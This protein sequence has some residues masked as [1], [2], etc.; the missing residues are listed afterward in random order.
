L[1]SVITAISILDSIELI[2][3]LTSYPLLHERFKA[4]LAKIPEQIKINSHETEVRDINNFG[5]IYTLLKAIFPGTRIYVNN[6]EFNYVW[7]CLGCDIFVVTSKEFRLFFL[8]ENLV[9]KKRGRTILNEYK[10]KIHKEL[11][12]LVIK[13][14]GSYYNDS[15]FNYEEGHFWVEEKAYRYYPVVRHLTITWGGCRQYIFSILMHFV[16][17]YDYI[18][19]GINEGLKLMPDYKKQIPYTATF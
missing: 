17:I 3:M 7:E 14:D 4:A 12:T 13:N 1:I 5:A 8:L 11:E 19:R 9:F 6:Q 18:H 16:K 10:D 15:T 2:N